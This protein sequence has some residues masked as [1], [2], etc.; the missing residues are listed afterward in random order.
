MTCEHEGQ[1]RNG[2]EDAKLV[3][4][5]ATL[6]GSW[7]RV[8]LPVLRWPVGRLLSID[9][10]NAAYQRGLRLKSQQDNYFRVALQALNVTYA[11]T[12]EDLANIPAKGPL[13]VVANHPFGG[14]EGIILGDIISRVRSDSRCLG[15]YLLRRIPELHDWVFPVDPFGNRDS[16]PGNA[17][18]LRDAIRWVEDGGALVTFPAGEVSHLNLRE[19]RIVDSA[20]S[21]HVAAVIRRAKATALPIYFPGHNGF[22]FQMMG[23]IHPRLRTAMLVR[24]LV[25][26]GGKSLEARVGR[27]VPW[28]KLEGFGTDE[29]VTEHLRMA[30]YFMRHRARKPRRPA[31]LM[32]KPRRARAAQPVASAGD[33][34]AL[35]AEVEALGPHRTLAESREFAVFLAAAAEAPSLLREIGRLREITFREAGEG[36][37]RTLDLDRFDPYYHHLV[38][39][40]KQA[41]ELAGAYRLGLGDEI[42]RARGARG[43]YT[44]TLFR[45]RPE[46]RCRLGRA[47]E[48]GRSFIRAEYQR[49]HSCLAMLWKGIAE[50]IV[51]SHRYSMLFGPVSISQDYLAVSK[52]LM[53]HFL[54]R[55]QNTE[56][57]RWVS[58][59]RPYRLDALRPG[60][61]RRLCESLRDMD[62]VS[63]LISEVERDGKGIPV[64]LRQYLKLNAT[65]A[66]FNVDRA[67]SNVVDGMLVVELT[68]TDPKLLRRFMG[69]A[70]YDVFARDHGVIV[71]EA[72]GAGVG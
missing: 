51:R 33:P 54:R 29:A 32:E 52:D 70:G 44:N 56:L 50:V 67:F 58:A 15:N 49:R 28:S 5:G 59:R 25:N 72:V 7:A 9:E 19:R 62:D 18:S 68:R 64:L 10:V 66:C 37:G 53:V 48:L 24:E 6:E 60:D 26:K 61:R 57:S 46:F 45:F 42:L 12:A 16:I 30:S 20:W 13:V 23:L 22:L 71:E 21:T 41:Q 40:N 69:D 31:R 35:R 34:A 43:F 2:A 55:S 8:L 3:D 65:I 39:W 38:L 4:L 47:V 63:A 36:T 11:I 27:P 14:I 17:R 1:P